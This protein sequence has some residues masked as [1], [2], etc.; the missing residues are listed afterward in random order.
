MCGD[1]IGVSLGV[2]GVRIKDLV[3]KDSSC[4]HAL[5]FHLHSHTLT[6]TFLVYIHLK[7]LESL[8]DLVDDPS[9]MGIVV[10]VG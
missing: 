8:P 9:G 5:I 4:A 3:R 6:L 1:V 7:F 10:V 2:I